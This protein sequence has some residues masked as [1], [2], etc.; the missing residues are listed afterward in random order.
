MP[1][2]SPQK[3]MAISCTILMVAGAV[4][5]GREL[6]YYTIER[7][8]SV[9][10]FPLADLPRTIGSWRLLRGRKGKPR[11][12]RRSRGSQVRR[13]TSSANTGMIDTGETVSV[14]VLYG[15]AASVS[16][17]TAKVCYPAAGYTTERGMSEHKL[18]VPGLQKDVR[19]GGGYFSKK[20]AG[21]TQYN[22]VVSSFRHAGDWLAD[23]ASRWKMFRYHPGCFKI[24]IERVCNEFDIEASPSVELLQNFI[25]EI[26]KRLPQKGRTKED[27]TQI[28]P[29]ESDSKLD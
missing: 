3:W 12:T 24:Q 13:I 1:R 22:E 19:Y 11:L 26:E 28:R 29:G 2:L 7:E 17:H 14:L 4:R 8:S 10:P 15:L 5:I 16:M 6:Q 21:Y 27:S 25:L 9:C 20:L 18:S 23:A